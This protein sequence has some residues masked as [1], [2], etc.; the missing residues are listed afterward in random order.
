MS[1]SECKP[2]EFHRRHHSDLFLLTRCNNDDS[3]YKHNWNFW[4]WLWRCSLGKWYPKSRE[5]VAFTYRVRGQWRMHSGT[6][7][8][9]DAIS[10][11]RRP[12]SLVTPFWKP[13]NLYRSEISFQP[14]S[15]SAACVDKALSQFEKFKFHVSDCRTITAGLVATVSLAENRNRL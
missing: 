4:Y 2:Y 6:P 5:Q 9:R 3:F 7:T 14:I 15:E 12:E 1:H 8:H 11:L 13:H 10:H